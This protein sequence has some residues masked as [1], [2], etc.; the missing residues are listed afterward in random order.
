V[1]TKWFALSPYE[2]TQEPQGEDIATT[3]TAL[4]N[5]AL[6]FLE[7]ASFS[8]GPDSFLFSQADGGQ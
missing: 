1:R 8:D 5:P 6:S 7:E 2:Q 4:P 3:I